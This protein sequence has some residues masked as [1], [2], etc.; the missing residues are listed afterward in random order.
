MKLLND[1]CNPPVLNV[2]T[3]T[4]STRSYSKNCIVDPV[5]QIPF[6][7][8]DLTALEL[9]YVFQHFLDSNGDVRVFMPYRTVDAEVGKVLSQYR[10]YRSIQPLIQ[11]HKNTERARKNPKSCVQSFKLSSTDFNQFIT[12]AGIRGWILEKDTIVLDE[13]I[14]VVNKLVKEANTILRDF[15]EIRTVEAETD[16]DINELRLRLSSLQSAKRKITDKRLELAKA[17]GKLAEEAD[18]S[19]D[20]VSAQQHMERLNRSIQALEAINFRSAF[21]TILRRSSKDEV[22]NN[23]LKTLNEELAYLARYYPV[24]N[25]FKV[26]GDVLVLSLSGVDIELEGTTI[27]VKGDLSCLKPYTVGVSLKEVGRGNRFSNV[28]VEKGE[29]ETT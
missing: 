17:V 7:V 21:E 10:S 5:D 26:K 22:T 12:E 24:L 28:F 4:S 20:L 8:E 19:F 2:V 14:S 25:Q 18:R 3:L 9:G 27:S 29:K 1:R 11:L 15:A 6:R 23:R 13:L 16:A